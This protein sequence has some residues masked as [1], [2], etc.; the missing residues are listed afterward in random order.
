M[1]KAFLLIVFTICLF[2]F[3]NGTTYAEEASIHDP[4]TNPDAALE[5]ASS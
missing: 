4:V 1:N 5:L 3:T 2:A